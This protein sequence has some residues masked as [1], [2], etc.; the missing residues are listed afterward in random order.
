MAG[1]E[2]ML[3]TQVKTYIEIRQTLGYKLRE[4]K[5]ELNLFAKFMEQRKENH[6][7]TV[8]AFAW[9]NLAPSPYARERRMRHIVQLA[10][11]LS[12]IMQGH[13]RISILQKKLKNF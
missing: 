11:Y 12:T 13:F 6:I 4:T 9:A 7:N 3:I 10:N 8:N 1:G 2:I 5:R